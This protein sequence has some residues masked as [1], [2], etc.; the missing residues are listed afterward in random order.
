MDEKT[1]A[2]R[3]IFLEV[4]EDDTVTESQAE[5]RGS[6]E[7]RS[8][9]DER[10]AEVLAEMRE[11]YEFQTGLDDDALVTVVDRFYEGDNDTAIG[12]ELGVSR[13]TVVRA[14]LE[15]HLVRERDRDAPFDVDK[16]T[17]LREEGATLAELADEFDVSESTLRRYLKVVEVER[18]SRQANQRYR[19][20]FDE[21]LADADLTTRI[22]RNVHE[23]GLDEATEGLES[24][25]SF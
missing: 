23:D 14:R 9:K 24:N 19:A 17:R 20:A 2:L 15:L 10:L 18:R 12:D 7:E 1:E 13:K 4:A 6:L 5:Q 21:I 8:D 22:T 11:R 16:A 25:V 3:D